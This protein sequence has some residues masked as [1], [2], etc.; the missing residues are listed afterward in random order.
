MS[1]SREVRE[2][3]EATA[4]AL[5]LEVD[6]VA[7]I[8]EELLEQ[9]ENEAVDDEGVSVTDTGLR[10][11]DRPDDEAIICRPVAW[12]NSLVFRPGVVWYR[13]GDRFNPA[14]APC[15]GRRDY[16]YQLCRPTI[17]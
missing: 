11:I 17:G 8:T 5:G 1:V 7:Y 2:A 10:V 4:K 6:D 16:H 15:P 12:G 13:H 14:S 9:Y 3:R